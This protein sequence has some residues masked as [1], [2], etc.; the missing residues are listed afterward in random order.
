MSQV[1]VL[2]LQIPKTALIQALFSIQSQERSSGRAQHRGVL[3]KCNLKAS[4]KQVSCESTLME[5][6]SGMDDL[7]RLLVSGYILVKEVHCTLNYS[8][9][10]PILLVVSSDKWFK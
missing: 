6:V 7:E 1:L 8:K 9:N 2:Y 10:I 5:V 3:L 4:A